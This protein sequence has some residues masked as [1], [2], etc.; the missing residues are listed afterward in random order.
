MLLTLSGMFYEYT[1]A[2]AAAAAAN[3]FIHVDV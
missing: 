2:A 1:A 3:L